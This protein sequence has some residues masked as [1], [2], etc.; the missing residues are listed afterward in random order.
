MVKPATRL[1]GAADELARGRKFR[2]EELQTLLLALL[3]DEPRHGYQLMHEIETRSN[4]C[5]RPSA[6]VIYPA[7]GHLEA[8][9]YLLP[10][11]AGK[12]KSY[13]LTEAGRR[14]VE[15]TRE[16]AQVLWAKLDFLGQKMAL[17][18]RA[19]AHDAASWQSDARTTGQNVTAA[20]E[21]LKTLVL[22]GAKGAPE[23]QR[24]IVAAL[25]RASQEILAAAASGT[26]N[27]V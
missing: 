25:Q 5:Y 14:E 18:R 1:R 6:G 2:S 4:G 23:E 19:F 8:A 17:V 11:A 26:D 10:V 12:R 16:S 22:A 3:G 27:P 7:L 24:R 9:G 13:Q 20:F 15:A 21:A